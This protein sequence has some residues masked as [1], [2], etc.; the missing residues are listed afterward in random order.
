MYSEDWPLKPLPDG[1]FHAGD[2]DWSP[3][4]IE[5][6]EFVDGEP[7]RAILDGAPFYRSFVP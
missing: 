4:R 1:R 7:A 6:D 3:R 5:F 2:E